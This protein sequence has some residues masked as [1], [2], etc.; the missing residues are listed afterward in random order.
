MND[1]KAALQ[2]RQKILLN[3]IDQSNQII[4]QAVESVQQQR[5][6]QIKAFNNSTQLRLTMTN[7]ML[8]GLT[9]LL[10]VMALGL[11]FYNGHLMS[12]VKAN[13]KVLNLQ[14]QQLLNNL[15]QRK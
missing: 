9:A 12:Q 5:L 8:G 14:Q 1:T 11:Y 3:A 15:N 6:E 13:A 10:A 4:F 2:Q 7:R